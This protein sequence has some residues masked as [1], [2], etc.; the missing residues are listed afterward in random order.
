[1]FVGNLDC[2][3]IKK[4]TIATVAAQAGVA[5]STVSRYLNG[6]YVSAPVQANARQASGKVQAEVEDKKPAAP[7]PDRLTLSKGAEGTERMAIGQFENR[8]DMALCRIE[9]ANLGEQHAR[10]TGHRRGV[11]VR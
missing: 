9:G 4:P 2:P 6:H 7:T 3:P 8:R 5:V 1:M 10:R 11:G